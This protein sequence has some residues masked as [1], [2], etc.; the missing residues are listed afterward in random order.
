MSLRNTSIG[1]VI[2]NFIIAAFF[3]VC[4]I[5]NLIQFINCDFEAPYKKEIIK[6]VGLTG[7]SFVTVFVA[8]DQK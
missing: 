8:N 1:I 2:F 3:L 7:L 4:W 5:V 6:G